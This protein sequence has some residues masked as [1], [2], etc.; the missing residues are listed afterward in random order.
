MILPVYFLRKILLDVLF[1]CQKISLLRVVESM[2]IN[3]FKFLI[4]SASS[5]D[6]LFDF[7]PKWQKDIYVGTYRPT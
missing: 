1:V 4:P 2:N 6:L 7:S 3:S 5:A